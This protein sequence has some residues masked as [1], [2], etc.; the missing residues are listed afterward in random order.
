MMPRFKRGD[1]AIRTTEFGGLKATVVVDGTWTKDPIGDGFWVYS[2]RDSGSTEDINKLT[3]E[4]FAHPED[5]PADWAPIPHSDRRIHKHLDSS[6]AWS[7]HI[8][9]GKTHLRTKSPGDVRGGDLVILR[10]MDA[11]NFEVY[12]VQRIKKTPVNKTPT[13]SDLSYELP[14]QRFEPT[15]KSGDEKQWWADRFFHWLMWL[16][17]DTTKYCVVESRLGYVAE[18]HKGYKIGLWV[19]YR[20]DGITPKARFY[21][22]T[23]DSNMRP[24]APQRWNKERGRWFSK[25]EDAEHWYETYLFTK[26]FNE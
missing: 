4:L 8:E 13:S 3:H 11:G 16:L 9:E 6:A 2:V 21:A 22:G 19:H 14:L 1:R 23:F 24:N 10:G 17:Q 26:E 25:L 7:F 20:I 15:V 12:Q 18:F 5:F